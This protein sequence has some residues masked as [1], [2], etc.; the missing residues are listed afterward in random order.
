M[1]SCV[2]IEH[3]A[4]EERNWRLCLRITRG[5]LVCLDMKGPFPAPVSCSDVMMLGG[6]D[7]L[8]QLSLPTQSFQVAECC[9]LQ[10]YT[11]TE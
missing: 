3:S 4:A 2:H 11:S 6:A 8:T 5:I 1:G 9:Y 10:L 7:A